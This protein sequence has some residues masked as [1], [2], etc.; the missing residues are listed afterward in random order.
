MTYTFQNPIPG[1]GCKLEY[2]S[3][4]GTTYTKILQVISIEPPALNMGEA[5][6]TALDSTAE[7]ATPTIVKNDDLSLKIFYDPSQTTHAAL[8]TACAAGTILFWKFTYANPQGPGASVPGSAK[9]EIFEG[10]VK[11]FKPTGVEVQG[12]I[13]ADLAVRVTGPNT[14]T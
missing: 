9:T 7:E 2:S 12:N 4:G 5:E 6:S 10:F 11:Q 14:R 8:T 3:D 1:K 13:Q